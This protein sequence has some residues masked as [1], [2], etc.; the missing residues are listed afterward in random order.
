MAPASSLATLYTAVYGKPPSSH[1]TAALLAMEQI[2]GLT[3]EDPLSRMMI[4]LMHTCDRVEA[5]EDRVKAALLQRSQ[6]ESQAVENTTHLVRE[7]KHLT[8]HL[9]DLSFL[10]NKHRRH[11]EPPGWSPAVVVDAYR[12]SSPLLS[13]L[14]KA[15]DR[16]NSV[17]DHNHAVGAARSDLFF[18]AVFVAIAILVGVSIGLRI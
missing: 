2:L 17:D 3:A 1:S 13:Y 14:C 7:I 4:V 15:F 6:D 5:V 8:P 9:G 18:V 16:R 12:K 11:A 10:L